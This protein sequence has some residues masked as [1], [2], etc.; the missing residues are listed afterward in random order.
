MAKNEKRDFWLSIATGIVFVIFGI[1]L[2]HSLS[3]LLWLGGAAALAFCRTAW[4]S[5]WVKKKQ[6]RDVASWLGRGTILTVAICA[7]C[8][9][10][11]WNLWMSTQALRES[12][13]GFIV[14]GHEIQG[15]CYASNFGDAK[16]RSEEWQRKTHQWLLDNLGKD[17]A[18]QFDSE[19]NQ[20][21]PDIRYNS[22]QQGCWK[23]VGG[24]LNALREILKQLG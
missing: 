7:V 8:F 14:E 10:G 15:T 17:K 3:T 22:V 9:W 19:Q 18:V 21:I 13:T 6:R 24:K 2:P 11:G 16:M 23:D 20:P 4:T 1:Y 12:I 5:S